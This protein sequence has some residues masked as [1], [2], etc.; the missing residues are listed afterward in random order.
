MFSLTG[1]PLGNYEVTDVSLALEHFEKARQLTQNREL[2]ARCA[3]W[4]AK[5]EQIL[6]FLSKDNHYTFSNK[7]APTVPP[8]YRR[9]FKLLKE[10]YS[11]TQFYKQAATECKYFQF[12]TTK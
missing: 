2:Q 3:F 1:F 5:C 4:S 12:Y 9:Y 8:Q 6:F 10:Y 11:D 7:I